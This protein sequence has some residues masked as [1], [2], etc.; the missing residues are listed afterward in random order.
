MW[1]GPA[2]TTTTPWAGAAVTTSAVA[3]TTTA[4]PA[5]TTTVPAAKT[6]VP[7]ATTTV[8]GE[9]TLPG[10]PTTTTSAPAGAGP[11][12]A[13]PGYW[14]TT[15]AGSVAS[16]GGV[17]YRGSLGKILHQP[18]VGVAAAAGGKG[19]WLADAN[20]AVYPIGTAPSLGS[21]PA[22]ALGTAGRVVGIA[23]TPDGQGYWLA[24]STGAVYGFG[25]A[26]YH[27]SAAQVQLTSPVVGIAATADGR[28]YWLVSADGGVFAFG[29][30]HY[31][32]SLAPASHVAPVVGLA[33]TTDGQ[34]YWL[35][36]SAGL[37]YG[38]GDAG[39]FSPA[40][41]LS[42]PV[43]A[44]AAAPSG[45]GYWL[46]ASDG[47]VVSAGSA[48][49]RGGGQGTLPYRQKA[50]AMAVGAGSGSGVESAGAFGQGSPS[51]LVAP[52]S[53]TVPASTTT[54]VPTTTTTTQATTTTTSTTTTSTTT[55][56]TTTT[57]TTTRTTTRTTTPSPERKAKPKPKTKPRAK[58]PVTA[59]TAPKR[60]VGPA[61]YPA[62]ARGYDISWPQCGGPLPPK[63]K[64]AVVGVNGGWAF[65]G[66]PC[67]SREAR[68]AGD[69]LTTYI[70]LNSPRGPKAADWQRGPAGKCARGNLYCESYNYGYN[71]A[72]FS[73][74]S[75]RAHRATSKTW[76][77]DVET[78]PNWLAS[79]RDNAR[80]IAGAIAALRSMHLRVAIYST[81]Y[82]WD[83]ITGGYVP[84]TSAWYPTGVAT[85][86]PYRWCSATSFAGGPVSLVQLAAGRYDGDYSC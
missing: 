46:L 22:G 82:M 1:A 32:G 50:V 44:I 47:T 81:T 15:N 77:L 79:Q 13:T 3:A 43:V 48:P 9:T 64:V 26:T 31:R 86:H 21:L 72:R 84:G 67:F 83:I 2:A 12:T 11:S 29:D 61:A 20:G 35:A 70:N 63:A 45:Q 57:T 18:I 73:V 49:N 53:T 62:G 24:T 25:D 42:S 85:P 27:G 10:Q 33:P 76:W 8:P 68:W 58:K 30:A 39:D 41:D 69:N 51:K 75:S 38:F 40:A 56:S 71:T 5:A 28:G 7:A 14:V 4:G 54:T 37:V 55:T 80:L 23:A 36:T 16:F 60:L 74:R 65:T 6:T 78:G 52:P 66:N 17:A 19:Y 59:T 34:G